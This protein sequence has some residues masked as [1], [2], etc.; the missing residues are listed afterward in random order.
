[1][2]QKSAMADEQLWRLLAS[3]AGRDRQHARYLLSGLLSPR[4]ALIWGGRRVWYQLWLTVAVLGGLGLIGGLALWFYLQTWEFPGG[5]YNI[6]WLIPVAV[7]GPVVARV[8]A[9]RELRRRT[10]VEADVFL[11][12]MR[13]YVDHVPP[14]F[15]LSARAALAAAYGVPESLIGPA[16]TR[17]KL[18]RLSPMST[19]LAIEVIAD[20]A[21]AMKLENRRD[22]LWAAAELFRKR[23]ISTV[24]GLVQVL[25]ADLGSPENDGVA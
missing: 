24:P 17:S 23:R 2:T 6:G 5:A 15:A 10:P 19:P 14:A 16:D 9:K 18:D 11:Q 8:M 4:P 12:E 25:Y 13:A 20:I 7:A 3:R 1:M 21:H 22:H